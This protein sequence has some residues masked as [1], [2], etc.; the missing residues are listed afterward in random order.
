[1]KIKLRKDLSLTIPLEAYGY[2]HL[3]PHAKTNDDMHWSMILKS[4]DAM[5]ISGRSVAA[6]NLEDLLKYSLLSA[7]ESMK[8]TIGNIQE[9]IK[10]GNLI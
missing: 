8:T 10:K 2:L 6:L 3:E 5:C 4:S 9:E 1:M 7:L